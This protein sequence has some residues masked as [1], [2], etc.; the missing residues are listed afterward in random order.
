[1]ILIIEMKL[2]ENSHLNLFELEKEENEHTCLRMWY[3]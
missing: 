1:M 2:G 3:Q